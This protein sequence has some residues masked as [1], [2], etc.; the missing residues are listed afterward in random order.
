[1]RLL[2]AKESD[3]LLVKLASCAFMLMLN[4]ASA[5]RDIKVGK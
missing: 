3:L 5:N 2:L 4:I 1:L